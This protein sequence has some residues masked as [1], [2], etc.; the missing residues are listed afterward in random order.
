MRR[1]FDEFR[2]TKNSTTKQLKT[3]L[4]TSFSSKAMFWSSKWLFYRP[5]ISSSIQL[6]YNT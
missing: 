1:L 5:P 6:S 4:D 2:Y 3:N